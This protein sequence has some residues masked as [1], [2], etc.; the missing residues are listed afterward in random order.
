MY[1]SVYNKELRANNVFEFDIDYNKAY[2][3]VQPQIEQL[4]QTV[5]FEPDLKYLHLK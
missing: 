2:K 1:D 3:L 5:L 4:N